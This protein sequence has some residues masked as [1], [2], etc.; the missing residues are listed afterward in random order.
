[1]F[2]SML[3]TMSSAV[4]SRTW[5]PSTGAPAQFV[6]VYDMRKSVDTAK[7]NL[8]ASVEG[9]YNQQNSGKKVYLIWSDQDTRWLPWLKKNHYILDYRGIPTFEALVKLSPTRKAVVCND[10]PFHITDVA[11]TLA[12]CKHELLVTDPNLITQF[13]LVTSDNLIGKFRSNVDAY[14][15][16]EKKQSSRI[17]QRAVSISAPYTPKVHSNLIDYLVANRIFTFWISGSKEQNLPGAN[18]DAE[19]KTLGSI[20][21]SKFPANIPCFGYPWNGD[22][23]GPGEGDGVTFLSQ[24]AKWLVATDTFDNLSF[25]STFPPSRHKLPVPKPPSIAPQTQYLASVVVSDGDNLCTF[26]GWFPKVWDDLAASGGSRLPVGWTMGPTLRELAPPIFDYATGHAP[27]GGSFGSGVSGIGYM[28]MQEWGKAYSQPIQTVRGFIRETQ[29]ACS[30]AGEKWL[31]LMRYGLP[32]STWLKSYENVQ[33]IGAIMGGYGRVVDDPN[34]SIESLGKI[35]VFHDFFQSSDVGGVEKEITDRM[36]QKTLP[37]RFQIFLIN[38]NTQA[39]DLESLAK[40]CAEKNIQLVAPEQ[41][42]AESEFGK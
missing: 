13:K 32:G 40:F 31:W 10:S 35:T 33:G 37:A 26:Q 14:N 28:A 16:L 39:S 21:L 42:A 15:W 9:L 36:A 19:Q 12:G 29:L 7:N 3:L 27:Q 11:T 38:W 1:M 2:L 5:I 41:L 25:W 30:L 8:A 6:L 20:L 23:Y 22:G 34:Q 17:S 18:T 24:H 4:N